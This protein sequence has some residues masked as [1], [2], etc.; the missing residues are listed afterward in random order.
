[1][2]NEAAGRSRVWRRKGR[3][4]KER[5]RRGRGERRSNTRGSEPSMVLNGINIRVVKR[6]PL[7]AYDLC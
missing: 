1:M 7:D 4:R 6:D 5:Q 2:R 3:G